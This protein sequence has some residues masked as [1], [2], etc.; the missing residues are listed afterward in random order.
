VG[1]HLLKVL[2][3]L[4]E[5][6]GAPLA[7]QNPAVLHA[8]LAGRGVLVLDGLAGEEGDEAGL[9]V[10]EEGLDAGVS[11]LTHDLD[12]DGRDGEELG[13]AEVRG[14]PEGVAQD[15]GEP[16]QRRAYFFCD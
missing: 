8:V 5:L 6:P 3:V 1:D 7:E 2:E 12:G 15:G 11:I 9:G 4:A 10:L 14:G 16:G 13:D